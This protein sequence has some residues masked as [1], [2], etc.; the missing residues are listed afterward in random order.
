MSHLA[1]S[2]SS[3]L[4]QHLPSFESCLRITCRVVSTGDLGRIIML[5]VLARHP[6]SL[7]TDPHTR[8]Q[9]DTSPIKPPRKRKCKDSL[10]D[11]KEGGGDEQAS[12]ATEE[13]VPTSDP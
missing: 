13:G 8:Y 12:K 5:R 11:E 9:L 2:T 10:L 3:H 4:A 6:N 7:P 1:M